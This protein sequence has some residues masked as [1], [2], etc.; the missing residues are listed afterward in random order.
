MPHYLEDLSAG[1]TFVTPGRTITE[2]DVISFA[3]WTN[4]NNQ[5]HTDAEF[6]KSTR[7]GQ[8]IVHG[9]LGTSLCLGLISRTGV[10]DGS[11]VALLGIDGW[12]FV[13]PL[14]IGDTVTCTV[15]VLS[16]RLTSSGTTGI[17]ERTVTLANQHGEVVQTGRMDIMVLTRAAAI[18]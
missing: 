5:V 14:F 4:D 1:Q 18:S 13:A 8:R 12:R 17:V 9:V 11:A 16:T 6:A 10:F 2:A 3:S 7:F 15:E